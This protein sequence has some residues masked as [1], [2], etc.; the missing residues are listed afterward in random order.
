[1]KSDGMNRQNENGQT[2]NARM[3]KGEHVKLQL[4]VIVLMHVVFLKPA[5]VAAA[6]RPNILFIYTDDQSYKTLS[7]YGDHPQWVQ[8]PNIDALARRGVR[9]E[10]AYLGAWCMPSRASILTG[11]LQHGV[12]TMRMEGPYP[13]SV[14]DPAICRF[15]PSEFRRQGYHTAQ[16]GKWHTGIDTGYG[17]D[18]D[19][20]IVWNRPGHPE[21][22][23]NYFKNQILTFNGEDRQVGGYS[24]DN[25]T[26]WALEYIRGE[27]RD[28]DKP[29]YLWLCYGAVHGPT[30]PAARHEGMHDG[31]KPVIPTDLF[32]PWPS[33]PAYLAKTAAWQLDSGGVPRMKPRQIDTKSNFN[34]N[35]AGKSFEDWIQQMNECNMAIDEGVGKLVA[36]LKETGQ[37]EN[38]LIVYAADQGYGLG[39]HGFNQKVAPYDATVASPLIIA[40]PERVPEAVVRE[41]AVNATDIVD[42][43]C[44]R[45][46]VEIP[47][48][49][50][51]RDISPLVNNTATDW[52]QPMIMTHTGRSYGSDTD[53]IPTDDRLTVV[54]NVPWYVLLRSG[55]YKYIMNL[56]A[57]EM[58][59]L[60]DLEKDP[61]ELHNLVADREQAAR[62]RQLRQ[63][64]IGE[65]RRTDAKYRLSSNCRLEGSH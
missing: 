13:A 21:N 50:H 42:F 7:C 8:T 19:Y 31:K 10:R 2:N 30:T 64:A 15:V 9:F 32:G 47:W 45:A 43:V 3:W 26:Q 53:Q 51:G 12:Q 56:T 41:E 35:D 28:A 4:L 5:C 29:W 34:V 33:K 25:Y 6:D 61:E 18:W 17:R 16:I 57:G 60:Y 63:Q 38:T 48:K 62:L 36:A 40:Q 37:Y 39:E 46:E 20:Q 1:M 58:E 23:G 59:E 54:G 44:Q 24:T 11:R 65:L 14:Y 55:R 27:N 49:M 22:A 52:D